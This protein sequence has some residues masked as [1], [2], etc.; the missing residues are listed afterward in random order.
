MWRVVYRE[1]RALT[2]DSDM[3]LDPMELNN[4]YEDVWNVGTL[5]Q[6]NECLTILDDDFRPWPKLETCKGGE[7]VAKQFYNVHD[8]NKQVITTPLPPF[9]NPYPNPYLLLTIYP[10]P[11]PYKIKADLAIL[12]A[13]ESRE[14]IESYVVVLK[15]IFNL[16]GAAMH[17]S[18]TRTLGTTPRPFP[19]PNPNPNRYPPIGQYLEATSGCLSNKNKSEWERDIAARMICTNNAAEGPFATV[20]AFLHIYP[21]LKLRTV[22]SLSAAVVNGTHRPAQMIGKR[23]IKAGLA[24][25]SPSEVKDAVS[26]LCGVRRRSPGNPLPPP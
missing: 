2:N 11:T 23:A 26:T 25:T 17:E 5:L 21:S 6:S 24:L 19:L 16:F 18:L 13:Y 8:R 15:K 1:L 4:I 10:T 9:P 22:A 20:R 14:D 7:A 12:R 3:N